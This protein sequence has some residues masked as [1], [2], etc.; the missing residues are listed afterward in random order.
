MIVGTSPTAATAEVGSRRRRRRFYLAGGI[1][2]VFGA[3]SVLWAVWPLSSTSPPFLPFSTFGFIG[4]GEIAQASY[5]SPVVAAERPVTI[6]S[7]TPILDERSAPA[8]LFVFLCNP[9]GSGFAGVH[10]LNG[11]NN[12]VP[13]H[14]VVE[15]SVG[16]LVSLAITPLAAG[17]VHID[18]FRVT[19]R[20][21]GNHTVTTGE[22]VVLAVASA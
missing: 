13:F 14:P 5:F 15:R 11:C 18:G 7:V 3:L 8:G 20:T 12:P 9:T 10:S 2:L 4:P 22:T 6:L 1:V 21:D 17:T 16:P 19:Y